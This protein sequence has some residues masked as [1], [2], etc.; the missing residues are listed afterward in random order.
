MCPPVPRWQLEQG[1]FQ[2]SEECRAHLRARLCA[3]PAT[4]I[5]VAAQARNWTA[6]TATSQYKALWGTTGCLATGERD[7]REGQVSLREEE[8]LK[9]FLKQQNI[10]TSTLQDS[11]GAVWFGGAL[12]G[13][14][15]FIPLLSIT[16]A[17][18]HLDVARVVDE[19]NFY[20]YLNLASLNLSSHTWLIA[21]VLYSSD[22]DRSKLG[23]QSKR[24]KNLF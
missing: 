4:D 17:T 23:N 16:M 21:S 7:L 10:W 1:Q 13:Y 22:L 11:D 2:A 5:Q 19:L 8:T 12:W 3:T 6:T 14:K 9:H 24:Q 18:E 20:C 15:H